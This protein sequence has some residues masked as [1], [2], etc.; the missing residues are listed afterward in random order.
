[1]FCSDYVFLSYILL[2]WYHVF[3]L[4]LCILSCVLRFDFSMPSCVLCVS[5]CLSVFS[6]MH[7]SHYLTCWSTSPVPL[8]VISVCV[9]SLCVPFTACPVIECILFALSH[10][11]LSTSAP[12]P[13]PAP[14]HV[15]SSLMVCFGFVFSMSDLYFAFFFALC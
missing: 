13:A 9:F 7:S 12:A 14:A 10:V 15:S 5:L 11:S 2:S 3:V 6:A 8:L 1:M 4:C